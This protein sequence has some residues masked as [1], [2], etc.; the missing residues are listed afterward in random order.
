[1]DE[2]LIAMLLERVLGPQQLQQQEQEPEPDPRMDAEALFMNRLLAQQDATALSSVTPSGR[3]SIVSRALDFTPIA[4]LADILNVREDPKSAAISG[5][6]AL[7]A[8]L[9]GTTALRGLS[10]GRR[11]L[12]GAEEAIPGRQSREEIIEG[13]LQRGPS[14]EDIVMRGPGRVGGR[15][16]E[17]LE[18][19]LTQGRPREVVDVEMEGFIRD[20]LLEILLR[21]GN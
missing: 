21:G 15:R 14:T 11:A 19:F 2:E 1:M 8:A 20:R 10:R 7:L 16:G 12:R 5:V 18:D 3:R 13:F 9:T 4:D 17:I 6:G